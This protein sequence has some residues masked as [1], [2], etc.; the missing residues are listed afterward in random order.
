[1]RLVTIHNLEGI[2]TSLIAISPNSSPAGKVLEPGEHMTE[3]EM[4]EITPD[5]SNEEIMKCLLDIMDNYKLENPSDVPKF[6]KLKKNELQKIN[7][8]LEKSFN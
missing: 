8:R 4:P 5:L 2:I 7:R 6:T 3:L 1:M